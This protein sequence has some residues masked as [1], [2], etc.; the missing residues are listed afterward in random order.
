M[1]LNR[2]LVSGEANFGTAVGRKPKKLWKVGDLVRHTGLSRQTLHNWVQLGLICETEQ[3]ESGHRLY[4]DTV[5]RRLEQIQR[6]RRRGKGL[7]QI[8]ELL[9]K[10]R[11]KTGDSSGNQD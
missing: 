7:R 9:R 1:P 10:R 11:E 3:T 6:Y 2:L 4:D 8:A 5:W